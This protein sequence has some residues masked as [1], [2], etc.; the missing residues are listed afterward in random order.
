MRV[1]IDRK[2]PLALQAWLEEGESAAL[3]DIEKALQTIPDAAQADYAKDLSQ[4][5]AGEAQAFLV[6]FSQRLPE[7]F[8]WPSWQIQDL[9]AGKV[10]PAEFLPLIRRQANAGDS[11]PAFRFEDTGLRLSVNLYYRG[12]VHL[13]AEEK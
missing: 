2:K 10:Q 6:K 7:A 12:V 13:I 4:M 1:R 8:T 11:L 3:K 9:H 5:L